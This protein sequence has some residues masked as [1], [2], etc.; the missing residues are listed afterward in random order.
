MKRIIAM[1]LVL[2]M[3]LCVCAFAETEEK[4][5]GVMTYAEFAAAD[6]ET[7][8][9]VETYIQDRQSWW[10]GTARFYTQDMEGGYYLYDMPC[11]EEEYEN[12]LTV[13]TKIKVTGF[14]TEWAGE[15]EIIDTTWEVLEGVYI[16]EP[17]DVTELL[18]TK[19]LINSQ[20]MLV[21][22]TGLT[23]EEYIEGEGPFSYG[24]DGSGTDGSDIYFSASLN[25][26]KYTFVVESDL[27]GAGT[28]V[29]EAVKALEL[30]QVIDMTGYLYW[31]EGVQPH[32]INVT[33]AE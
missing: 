13:G 30:G 5:E 1:V 20:N 31:Y 21:S 25:G 23:V 8:V 18:G 22:F 28:E 17:V 12:S 24:W 15:V 11:T 33:V 16:A 19:E 14:K 7:E 29:Y 26:E 3:S 32:V 2:M 27:R 6:I 4:G 9:T 10:Q